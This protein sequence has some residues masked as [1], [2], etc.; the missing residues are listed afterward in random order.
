[1]DFIN[2]ITEIICYKIIEKG[3]IFV[4]WAIKYSIKSNMDDVTVAKQRKKLDDM[5]T[6]E[7]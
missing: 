5:L 7:I 2:D 3:F 4:D 1:M 6:I